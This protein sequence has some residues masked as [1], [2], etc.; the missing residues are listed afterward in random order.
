VRCSPDK[1]RSI[2]RGRNIRGLDVPICPVHRVTMTARITQSQSPGDP[3]TQLTRCDRLIQIRA[4]EFL[5]KALDSAADK[6]L[7]SRSDYIRA[8]LLD[9]L[10]ADGIDA[11]RATPGDI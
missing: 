1:L 11:G 6:R 10:K 2:S 3:M 7:T 9:R 8:A 5:T 4:P